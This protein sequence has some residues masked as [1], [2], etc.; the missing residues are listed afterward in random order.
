[1]L[2]SQIPA[3]KKG[4][5]LALTDQKASETMASPTPLSIPVAIDTFLPKLAEAAKKA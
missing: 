5:Y 2:L 4:S 1:K 3:F